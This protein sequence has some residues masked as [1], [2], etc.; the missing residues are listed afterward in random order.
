LLPKNEVKVKT[1][2]SANMLLHAILV[3]L[4]RVDCGGFVLLRKALYI[5]LADPPEVR[6]LLID[7]VRRSN[8]FES[9]IFESHYATGRIGPLGRACSGA[10]LLNRSAEVSFSKSRGTVS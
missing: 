3:E 9:L 10:L 5:R 2:R 6:P 4:A 1:A 7:G 8:T